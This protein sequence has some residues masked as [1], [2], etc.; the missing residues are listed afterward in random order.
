MHKVAGFS[1]VILVIAAVLVIIGGLG[2]V[3]YRSNQNIQQAQNSTTGIDSSNK[4]I[5]ISANTTAHIS[6][7]IWS[8]YVATSSDVGFKSVEG[9]IRVPVVT[10]KDETAAFTA[11]V[12]FDGVETDTVEQTGITADC[13]NAENYTLYPP[14]NGVYYYA[15]SLMYGS[16]GS[17]ILDVDMKPGDIIDYKVTYA[18]GSYSMTVTNITTSQTDTDTQVCKPDETV[19]AGRGGCKQDSVEWI[20]ERPGNSPLAHFDTVTLYDNTATDKDGNTKY[21]E[22]FSNVRYD[23]INYAGVLLDEA[24]ALR[25]NGVFDVTWRASGDVGY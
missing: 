7:S 21:I 23:M 3:W 25:A 20:V 24:S 6:N 18:E 4:P 10:C 22:G 5:D 1:H 19:K 17:E 14:I 12:G 9:R 16:G 15:W 2:F 8:G 13:T 11:W